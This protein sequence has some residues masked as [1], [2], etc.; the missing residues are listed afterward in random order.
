M[1]TLISY[2]YR[3]GNNYKQ[4]FEL[5][6]PGKM[7]KDFILDCCDEGEYFIPGQVGLPE[8]QGQMINFPSDA[9]HV[10][11]EL[12]EIVFT[13]DQPTLDITAEQLQ[14]NFEEAKDNWQVE[15]AMERLGTS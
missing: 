9:D 4:G 7:D 5:I 8:L 3:D 12:E 2:I 6:V 1:N 10:W 13:D 14:Q 11:H 15:S